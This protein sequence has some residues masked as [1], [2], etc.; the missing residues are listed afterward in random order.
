MAASDKSVM[1]M[2]NG[3]LGKCEHHIEDDIVGTIYE[4][5]TNREVVA[6]WK[7]HKPYSEEC[8]KCAAYPICSRKLKHCISTVLQCPEENKRAELNDITQKMIHTYEKWKTAEA[9]K[10]TL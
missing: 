6:K 9:E 1:I 7:E 3:D 10:N 8:E 2:P 5:V 4:G